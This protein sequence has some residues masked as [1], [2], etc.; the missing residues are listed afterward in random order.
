MKTMVKLTLAVDQLALSAGD[1]QP[2]DSAEHFAPPR[3]DTIVRNFEGG[4]KEETDRAEKREEER[5]GARRGRDEGRER[6]QE[7]RKQDLFTS[8]ATERSDSRVYRVE[9]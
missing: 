9:D 7:W 5:S 4:S 1:P 6:Q 8:A 2:S 3:R